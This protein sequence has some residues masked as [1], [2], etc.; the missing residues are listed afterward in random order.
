MSMQ[1]Q[2]LQDQLFFMQLM[3]AESMSTVA[4]VAFDPFTNTVWY[5]LLLRGCINGDWG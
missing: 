4:L 3:W 1:D 5:E 2:P